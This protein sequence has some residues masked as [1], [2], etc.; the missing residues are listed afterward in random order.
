MS[1]ISEKESKKL[2]YIRFLHLSDFHFP[3]IKF[4]EGMSIDKESGYQSPQIYI[5]NEVYKIIDD[6]DFIFI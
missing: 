6:V 4:Q 2:E 1:S 5:L 3:D